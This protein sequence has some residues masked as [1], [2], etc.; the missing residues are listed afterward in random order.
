MTLIAGRA[1]YECGICSCY[2]PWE[3]HGDCREDTNRTF[4]DDYAQ[5]MGCPE[6][7]LVIFTM[8]ERV[9]ADEEEDIC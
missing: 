9:I 6:S 1:L 5:A 8:H 3:W 4:P 2:H 7:E